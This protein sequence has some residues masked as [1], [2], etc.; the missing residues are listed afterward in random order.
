METPEIVVLPDPA[1]IA[2]EAA[3]RFVAAAA[4]SI[5]ARGSF[6]VALAGGSTPKA[7]CRLLAAE[8]LRSQVDWVRT[9]IYFGDERVVLPDHADSNYRMAREALLDHVPIPGDNVYR[10]KGEAEPESAAKAYGQH[11]KARF[12]PDGGVD[13]CLL[14]MGDDGHT[15]SLFPGSPAVREQEH[16][17]VAQHVAKSTTGDSWRLTMTAPFLNRSRHVLFLVAGKSK[18]AALAEVLEG[19]RDPDRYPSQLINPEKTKVTWLIDVMAAG[20]DDADE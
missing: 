8:P 10:M 12:G 1:A 19:E 17:V 9:E 7:M 13:L 11:L 4:E 14:G 6:A 18:A 15:A 20:M 5:A 2:R 16:R 3:D